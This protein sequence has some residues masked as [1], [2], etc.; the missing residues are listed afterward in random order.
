[1]KT[2]LGYLCPHAGRVAAGAAIKFTAAVLELI[3]PLLLAEVID[4]LVPAGDT[5]AIWRTGGWMSLLA[6]GAVGCNITANRMAAWVSMEMTR[7]LRQDLYRRIQG[8]SCTQADQ[9]SPFSLVSRLTND[10]YNVHQMFDKVQRGGIRAPH[11]GVGR[12]DADLSAGALSGAGSAGGEPS[13][14]SHHY[15]GDPA[16]DPPLHQSSGGC[17]HGGAHPTGERRRGAGGKGPRLSGQGAGS[18]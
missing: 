17:G 6:L 10:T 2:V 4:E 15:A 14:L 7:V 3:L 9:F 13:H 12:T 16:G 1:M 18:L 8:L 5:A 11:A